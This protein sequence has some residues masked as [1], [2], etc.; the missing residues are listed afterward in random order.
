MNVVQRGEAT[1][2]H[3]IAAGEGARSVKPQDVCRLL[4]HT[5]Q[6]RIALGV[7]ADVAP[8]AA[9]AKKTALATRT[10]FCDG[11]LQGLRQTLRRVGW[12]LQ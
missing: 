12:V 11:E 9:R 1:A 7:S 4:H 10:H 3:M 5:E 8:T 2:E 6:T